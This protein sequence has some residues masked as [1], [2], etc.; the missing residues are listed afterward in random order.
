LSGTGIEESH[1][2]I[3]T[4][5]LV[6]S[7]VSTFP[8]V[9]AMGRKAKRFNIPPTW[10]E[11][12]RC[13]LEEY[14][15]KYPHHLTEILS[16]E[17]Y[18]GISRVALDDYLNRTYFLPVDQGGKGNNPESSSLESAVRAYRER[19]DGSVR[20]GYNK[21]FVETYTWSQL[22]HACTA[23][24]RENIIVVVYGKPG[25]GKS[26]CL[27]EYTLGC[28][29]TAPVTILC[30]RNIVAAY[31]L[32]KIAKQLGV[33]D[34][35]TIP[36]L[37]DAV[38]EKLNSYPRPL[39][40][41]QANYLSERSLGSV[42]YIWEVAHI[43]IM[44]SGTQA[45][46]DLFTTSPLTEDVRAQLSSRV[47]RHYLLAELSLSEAKAIIQRALGADATDA[48]IAQIFSI[49][50]GIHRHVDMIIP[51]ILELKAQ[52]EEKLSTRKIT[53]GDIIA[54]AGR[55]LML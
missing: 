20:H 36:Q 23:A 38:A 48:V 17:Q 32:K 24:I 44:L 35:G 15:N 28:M 39:F 50:G 42:C 16:R 9:A 53:I 3:S 40:V 10:D 25:V 14:I 46:Y 21:P 22:Q 11:E 29:R 45:L 4:D 54:I 52:N 2:N 47:A 13:W 26:R 33:K 19:V 30:S 8:K 34:K 7:I 37:E 55:R 31:F 51:L 6:K 27:R 1:S 43:P 12:L 18:I 41:D 49:T 5:K